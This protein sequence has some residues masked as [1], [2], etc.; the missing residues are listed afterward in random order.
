MRL[1]KSKNEKRGNL[2][3]KNTQFLKDLKRGV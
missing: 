2:K 3:T 1:T